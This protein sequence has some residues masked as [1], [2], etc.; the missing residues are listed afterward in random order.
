MNLSNNK[1]LIT[2]GASGI[3]LGLTERFIQ[4]NNTVIICG[5]R[6]SVLND[7]KAKFPSVITKVCDLS[8]E[9][10]RTALYE[11]IAANHPDLNVLINNAGI[12]NW[13]SITDTDFYANMKNE[14][15]TNIEAPLHLT[16]LFIQLQSL[17][18]V[19][20]VTSGLAFSPFA[21]VPVYSAT[22]AFFRS[23]TL[24][25]RHL[26]KEKNIEVIEIIPPALNTDLGGIGLHDAHPSVS[27]FI[28]SIFEQLKEGRQELTFGTSET[29][30][31][32]SVPELKASF[33]AL[34]D[35]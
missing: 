15:T 8:K 27:S 9:E 32:A 3:G 17:K 24:S 23:F 14:L 25:L 16:S 20:N 22:K 28:E 6:E 13:M 29:R 18:T 1:I 2:G 30:L 11:W 31:N 4:E 7:V 26:L 10:D 35:N 5:R 33:N 21:K 12:Q 19:M 34:H